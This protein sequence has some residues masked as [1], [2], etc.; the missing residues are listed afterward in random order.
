MNA[1]TSLTAELT[2]I[3]KSGGI[4]SKKIVL[5]EVHERGAKPKSA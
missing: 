1:S 3:Q 4:L 2:G 5:A